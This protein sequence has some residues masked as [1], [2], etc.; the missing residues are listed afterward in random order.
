MQIESVVKRDRVTKNLTDRL[1]P[2]DIALISH[3]DLDEIA[4]LSL[5]DKQISCIINTETTI[6]GKYPNKGPEAL[7]R[8]DIPIFEVEDYDLLEDIEENDTIRVSEEGIFLHNEKISDCSLLGEK[9]IL[10]LL[11]I[12]NSNVEYELDRFIENTLEYAKREKGLVTGNIEIPTIKTDLKGRH[13][14]IVVRG[15][16]YKRDFLTIKN[17][18]DEVKPILVGVDGGADAIVEF[19]YTPNIVIGDMDSVSDETLKIAEEVVVHAFPN[20]RAPGLERVKNLGIEPVIFK[21]PG[22]SEDI[23]LLLSYEKNADLI[24]ALGTHTNMIDFLEKGRPGMASTFLVRLKVGD[25][26][27]D[28]RGVNK[29][30]GTSFE[31][32]YFG[33]IILAALIPIIILTLIN[34]STRNLIKLIKI[35]LRLLL[36][37]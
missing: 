32:K 8:A 21:S 7:L 30:Y 2:G 26:F 28:A 31:H 20:G 13:V 19:G 37:I 6:S 23:A 4:A 9:E 18:I 24:V 16:D 25:R 11:D 17:Y 22:T 12:A 14:L 27:V 3:K 1:R 29:L 10:E 34:P 5:I 36:G 15:K 35:R 33:I